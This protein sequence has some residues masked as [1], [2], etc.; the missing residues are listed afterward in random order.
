MIAAVIRIGS[1]GAV[2]DFETIP[3]VVLGA[4]ESGIRLLKERFVGN[5]NLDM[6]DADAQGY[7]NVC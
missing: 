2:I 7:C 4:V 3:A 1:A 6:G 5:G